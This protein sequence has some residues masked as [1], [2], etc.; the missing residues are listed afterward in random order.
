MKKAVITVVF[1]SMLLSL[2]TASTNL[3]VDGSKGSSAPVFKFE[4]NDT[5]MSI[6]K[7]KGEWVLLQFWASTD[8]KS[9]INLKQYA[10]IESMLSE[11]T[12]KS[13]FRHIGVNLDSNK[14]LFEEIA[15]RDGLSRNTQF[16]AE[17]NR[18]NRLKTAYHLDSDGYGAF[19]INPEGKIVAKNPSKDYLLSLIRKAS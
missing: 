15:R 12:G 17:G 4:N 9:R 18:A 2:F 6:D 13:Q 1:F 5:T 19:L 7:M 10:S 8:A 3:A 14:Q 11:S 16:Y